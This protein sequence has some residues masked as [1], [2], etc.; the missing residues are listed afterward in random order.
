MPRSPAPLPTSLPWPVFTRPEALAAK[1]HG[2]RL[3][4]TDIVR[5]RRGLFRRRDQPL[6][7]RDLALAICRN[8]PDA[9]IVGLTAAHLHELALPRDLESE[10][11]RT[12]VHVA[13]PGGRKGSD[14]IVRWHNLR[15]S[16]RDVEQRAY[17]APRPDGSWDLQMTSPLR[18][19]S[20]ARTWRDLA[21]LVPF[22]RLVATGD[23]LVRS[24]RPGLENGRTRPWCTREELRAQCTG[25]H[26]QLL[27]RALELVRPGAD[28]PMETLLR[29][30]FRRA[31][32]PTPLLNE[33]LIATDGSTLHE[34]DFQWPRYKICVEYEGASHGDSAQVERDIRRQRR[35][36]EGGWTELRLYAEDTHG[37]CAG[38][39]RL[40]TNQLKK[41]GWQP[42]P[43]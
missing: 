5:L 16:T 23:S 8:D 15:L 1:V 11:P 4:R 18:L 3:R 14:S 29:L 20:R 21:S 10:E 32:L 33:P 13:V 36:S 19:S 2:E 42:D 31:G 30:A 40:V 38:A 22:W 34:P 9:V 24:P 35:A 12:P 39:V 37:D 28:S 27:R 6:T 43:R 17:A 26:A 25:I 7:E 41:A